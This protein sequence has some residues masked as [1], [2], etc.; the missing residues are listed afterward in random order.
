MKPALWRLVLVPLLCLVLPGAKASTTPL[1]YVDQALSIN[2]Q[3]VNARVPAGY[4]LELLT[5]ALDGP[6]LL[7]FSAGG[8]LFIGSKS[9]NV[10]RLP[11][12]YTRPEVLVRLDDYPHGVAF[13]EGSIL[14]ARTNGLY[15]A[16]YQPGQTRL[17][18]NVIRLLAPLP[19]GSGHNSRSVAVGPD[20]R[21][22]LGLGITGNCS[23]EYLDDTYSFGNR[24]G[25]VFVLDEKNGAA[26]W[27]PF[28]SGLRNPVGFAWHPVTGALY[29]SNNGPDHHGY[30]QPP[31]YF[32]RIDPGSFHGMPWFQFDGAR[33]RPD[34]CIDAPVPRPLAEV[35]APAITFPA[36]NAP[37]GVAF[38]SKG[39]MDE[40]L[41]FD[42]IVALH[43]SWATLPQGNYLGDAA[44]RRPPAVVA[45]RFEDGRP[46]RVDNLISGF[47]LKDGVRWARPVGVALGPD[48]ALYFTSDG[49]THGLFR[50]RPVP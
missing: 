46:R 25:G 2:G 43:G 23:N 9:G 26:R 4:R 33:I 21:I 10:Y 14:I 5:T 40:R 29:A 38:V 44:T 37:M 19:G 15:H 1:A 8:D 28:G 3:S 42:A 36:R 49:G 39:A 31:E 47:Q 34:D 12:P 16:P 32:S 17:A 20:Q 11:P 41:E 50:L 7:T 35:V 27:Q 24:R 30:E 48:G 45:V 22:Y 18:H 13:R 6:R